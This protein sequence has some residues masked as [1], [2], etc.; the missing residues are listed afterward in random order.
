MPV[1]FRRAEPRADRHRQ[2]SLFLTPLPQNATED[3]VRTR[4]IQALPILSPS[5]IRSIVHVSKSRYVPSVRI[6]YAGDSP[7]LL[8]SSAF[9]NFTSRSAAERAA[10]AW[11]G[12]L[13]WD[14]A[15]VGVKWG[16]SKNRTAAG[17][18]G[19]SGG[20][21]PVAGPSTSATAEAVAA[22]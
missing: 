5:D 6:V 2:Q 4:V 18:G 3:S 14:G 15:V 13:D 22:E 16:R 11:A 21:T 1:P 7:T 9:V 20:V 12:G 10:E 19:G 17:G 8:H